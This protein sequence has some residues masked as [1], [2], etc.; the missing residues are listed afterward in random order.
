MKLTPMQAEI[1]I[2]K[3]LD[4]GEGIYIDGRYF[5]VRVVDGV[6]ELHDAYNWHPVKPNAE[7]RNGHGRTLFVYE[8]LDPAPL[9][10][11]ELCEAA[12]TLLDAQKTMVYKGHEFYAKE[13]VGGRVYLSVDGRK[14]S[15]VN[16]QN[17]L[18]SLK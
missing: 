10:I 1:K 7:F 18:N 15:K 8:P 3:H 17:L 16:A 2:R 4:K 11:N 5:S 12:K 13:N 14:M 6:L 9:T